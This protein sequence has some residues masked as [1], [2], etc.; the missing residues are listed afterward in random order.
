MMKCVWNDVGDQLN[1]KIFFGLWIDA[2]RE[3]LNLTKVG[4]AVVES[5]TWTNR[6]PREVV[7]E[8]Q[9]GGHINFGRQ[10]KSSLSTPARG[11]QPSTCKDE[12]NEGVVVKDRYVL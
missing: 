5:V 4:V 6:R 9:C 3:L 2:A 8:W 11:C 12:C 10:L 1:D 7:A